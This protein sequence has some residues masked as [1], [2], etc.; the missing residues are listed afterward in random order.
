[1]QLNKLYLNISIS[2]ALIALYLLA[3]VYEPEKKAKAFE[4][5]NE[6]V[7]EV[8]TLKEIQKPSVA[9]KYKVKKGDTLSSVSIRLYGKE[10]IIDEIRRLNGIDMNDEIYEGMEILLPPGK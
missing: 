9:I 7:F 10:Q 6:V 3:Q 1:M 2:V 8:R 4:P 5:F